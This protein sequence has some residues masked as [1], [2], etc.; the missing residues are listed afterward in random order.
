PRLRPIGVVPAAPASRQAFRGPSLAPSTRW[1]AVYF[2]CRGLPP[3]AV[4]QRSS[5]VTLRFMLGC[6]RRLLF[7]AVVVGR[8]KT[9]SRN[10][11]SR[12]WMRRGFVLRVRALCRYDSRW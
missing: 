8:F 2:L 4:L 3:P 11:F 6:R 9:A 10:T 7:V 5:F 1:R 12:V